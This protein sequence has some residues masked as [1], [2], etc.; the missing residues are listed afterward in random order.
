M[1]IEKKEISV[2]VVTYNRVEYLKQSLVSILNQTYKNISVIILDNYSTD[3]TEE[4]IQSLKDNR[5]HYIRHKKNIGGIQNIAYA[6]SHCANEYFAVFH[7]DDVLHP[8]ILERELEYLETHEECAAVSCHRNIIDENSALLKVEKRKNEIVCKGTEF[9]SNYLNHQHSFIF[10]ATLY[11]TSFVKKNRINIK[12]EPGPCADVVV[13]FDIEKAGGTVAELPDALIDYR[14]Y[15][16]QDSSLHLEMMLVQLIQYLSR[17][18]YYSILLCNDLKGRK[19]YLRWYY[20]RLIARMVSSFICCNEAKKFLTEMDKA[21]NHPIKC[22]K[23]YYLSLSVIDALNVP[24][25]IVY[26]ILKKKQGCR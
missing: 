19:R 18:E 24:A 21:L 4:Y 6:F 23:K 2:F 25:G 14:V 1:K 13:Y 12:P 3:G 22:I 15:K 5:I 8:T 17:D 11:K 26:K 9:F 16:N 10:P 20:R 7:D